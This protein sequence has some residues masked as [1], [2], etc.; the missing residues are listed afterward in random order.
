MSHIRNEE[1]YGCVEYWNEQFECGEFSQP[2]DWL[3]TWADLEKHIS[4]AIPCQDARIL[5]PGCGNAPFQLE[6][7][8]AGYTNMVCGDNSHAAIAQMKASK[9]NG[10]SGIQWDL[11]DATSMPYPDASFDVVIEKSLTDCL[12]CCQDS[13]RSLRSYLDEVFR[14]LTPAGIFVA[15]TF[16]TTE[17]MQALLRGRSW[18]VRS[19]QTLSVSTEDS[20]P[21]GGSQSS[22]QQ[23]PMMTEKPLRNVKVGQ[24]ETLVRVCVCTKEL[25]HASVDGVN[26]KAG[27]GQAADM[28][29]LSLKKMDR[30]QSKK[31][32][33]M[34]RR[35]L[36]V[37]LAELGLESA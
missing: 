24:S 15:V 12:Y 3:A 8:E 6:M 17:T 4:P 23:D 2:F 1:S 25:H 14:V 13:M 9:A 26:C 31:I 27:E 19:M 32:K 5:I 20:A 34:E 35:M 30:N 18:R 28:S 33:K 11:M 16:Q 10:V 22:P 7:Y 21:E 36:R 29:N 37:S